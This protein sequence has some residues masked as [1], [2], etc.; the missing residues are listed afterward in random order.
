MHNNI[1]QNFDV[2]YVIVDP[3][4]RSTKKF[5]YLN[6]KIVKIEH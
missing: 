6:K 2:Y 3:T 1:P 5:S 4:V